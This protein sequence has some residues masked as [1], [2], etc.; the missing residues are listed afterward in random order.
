MLLCSPVIV[1]QR[2]LLSS[3]T[4]VFSC[5]KKKRLFRVGR[6]TPMYVQQNRL[7]LHI[8][9]ETVKLAHME[10]TVAYH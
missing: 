9:V 6:K 8:E 10:V 4:K 5:V 2:L 7:E 1:F 3:K